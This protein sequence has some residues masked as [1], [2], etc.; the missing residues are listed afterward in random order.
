MVLFFVP[1]FRSTDRHPHP[2]AS[3]N[4]ASSAKTEVKMHRAHSGLVYHMHN[5]ERWCFSHGHLPTFPVFI[6][7]TLLHM[8]TASYMSVIIYVMTWSYLI[9]RAIPAV[10]EINALKEVLWQQVGK[11]L[12][13]SIIALWQYFKF[14]LWKLIVQTL[15]ASE[16]IYFVRSIAIM[17]LWHMREQ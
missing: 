17:C 9:R 4:I 10:N 5:K 2:N 1:N 12:L 8:Y 3:E 13:K 15:S 16:Q 11:F 6:L 7:E 14:F